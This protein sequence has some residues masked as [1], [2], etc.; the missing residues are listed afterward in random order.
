PRRPAAPALATGGNGV[1]AGATREASVEGKLDGARIQVHRVGDEVRIYTRNLNDVTTRLPGIVDLARVLPARSFLLDGEA[2]GVGEDEL[3][4]V[5][6]DTM[7]QFGRQAEGAG[8]GLASRFFDI[9]HLDGDD[10]I[11][12]PPRDRLR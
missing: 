8:A 7:S 6:Q 5:F 3:P 10:L 11:D 9:L 2:I 1:D 4:P 12:R